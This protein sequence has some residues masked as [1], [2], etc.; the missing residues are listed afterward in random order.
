MKKNPGILLLVLV[1]LAVLLAGAWGVLAAWRSPA[2]TSDEDFPAVVFYGSVLSAATVVVGYFALGGVGRLRGLSRAGRA[3][4]PEDGEHASVVGTLEAR[5][6]DTLAGPFSGRPALAYRYEVTRLLRV[7]RNRRD[8]WSPVTAFRGEAM[9]PCEIRT[10]WGPVPLLARAELVDCGDLVE[11]DEAC[12]RAQQFLAAVFPNGL[13][14]Q[15]LAATASPTDEEADLR[16][17]ETGGYRKDERLQVR[18][19]GTLEHPFDVSKWTL[20]ETVFAQGAKVC[21]SGVW[22]A[23]RSGLD[24]PSG[25]MQG[26]LLELG[27]AASAAS[28]RRSNLGCLAIV[29]ALLLFFQVLLGFKVWLM[30]V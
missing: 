29:G 11:G 3:A 14:P 21:A 23:G 9:V 20:R 15:N 6:Q 1:I 10:E 19:D 5:S 8:S 16:F 2:G 28:D 22:S 12:T 24:A 13:D 7:K 26:L 4:P 27:D 30:G 18:G 25:A 17:R